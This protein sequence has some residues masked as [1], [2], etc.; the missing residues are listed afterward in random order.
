MSVVVLAMLLSKEADTNLVGS[1]RQT[2]GQSYGDDALIGSGRSGG[3]D[4]CW[5]S[6]FRL[7]FAYD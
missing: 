1:S 2:G 4:D 7:L 3:N 5:H 6:F